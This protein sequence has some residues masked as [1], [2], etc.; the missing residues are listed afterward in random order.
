[1]RERPAG[2]ATRLLRRFV[3]GRDHAPGD[4]RPADGY[5]GPSVGTG[6]GLDD[7]GPASSGRDVDVLVIGA[8]QAGLGT[9]YHLA[10]D[11]DLS[12]LVLDA[13]PLGQSWLDRWDSL[14]LFT[15]RR[16]SSLPGLRFPD[17]PGGCPTRT[18]MARYLRDYAEHFGLP[19]ET[20]VRVQR[21]T[22]DGSGFQALTSRGP[23]RA[24][25]VV[26]ATGPF[27]RP[28]R[29]SASAELDP[30]VQQLHSRDY[31]RPDDV[32]AGE[33]LVVGGGNSAAQL[34]L[35]LADAG[36]QVTVASPGRPWFLPETI[37]GVSMYWW[38]Y[39]TGI[40]NADQDAA[41]SRSI[42]RRGDAIV[43][44]RL[45]TLVRRGR[46]RLLP[47]RVTGA[48]GH[49]VIL[50]DG[51]AVPVTSVLWCTG[52]VPDQPWLDVPGAVDD[53]GAPLHE[54][55]ASPVPGLHW[56]GLPWQTRLNS[57]IIDGVDRD[58][59]ATAE[60]ITASRRS[61]LTRTA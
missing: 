16:F 19:V 48:D 1:M 14:Q 9:A 17:G 29:P 41:V 58:A 56:M 51:T 18:E 20:G 23:V 52:F 3:P 45:R 15:P 43:G 27:D 5:R 25:H 53:E 50:A 55:G 10:A 31:H 4:R 24:D 34:A 2:G 39:L 59:R 7:A 35:E 61:G 22:R 33:V 42:R 26:V 46:V 60:R 28:R 57:S 40:L 32:P 8:G 11:R 13:A 47:H 37:L 6:S 44:T 12:V 21:L 38:I 36:R 54:E 49:R 30:T